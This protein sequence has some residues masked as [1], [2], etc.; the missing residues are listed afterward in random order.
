M[1]DEGVGDLVRMRDRCS[2][3]HDEE[4][5]LGSANRSRPSCIPSPF[6]QCLIQGRAAANSDSLVARGQVNIFISG[7]PRRRR[8]GISFAG[9]RYLEPCVVSRCPA[10]RK[11]LSPC[12]LI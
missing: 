8:S 12:D 9:N 11:V 3:R 10:V 4:C 7:G 1:R 5:Q 6:E 2:D